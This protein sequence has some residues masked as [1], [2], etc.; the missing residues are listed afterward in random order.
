MNELDNNQKL[1]HNKYYKDIL[2]R[3]IEGY[4]GFINPDSI[5]YW[6]HIYCLDSIK[7][8]FEKIPKSYFLTVGDGY[9]GREAGFIKRFG[10]KVH[11]SD[12]ETCLIEISKEK[13]IIDEYSEQDINM[14]SFNDNFFDYSLV[15]ESL[16]HLSKPYNGIYEMMRVSKEGVILIEPNGDNYKK[17][18]FS[19]FEESGN[20]CFDFN[21]HELY[22]IGLSMG[23][24]Y[25]LI[26]YSNMFYGQHN[27]DN[28][29]ND[30]IVEEKKRLI[31]I[32]H[33]IDL[34]YKPLLIF[35][36]LKN[37]NIYDI[38]NGNNFIKINI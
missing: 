11:A 17:Y 7:E 26:S 12:I 27:L 36:F 15:K 32:D 23:Y 14:L 22:K 35:I 5:W 2:K 24:K 16:H 33:K 30:K 20:Y 8:F 21:S 25:F 3:G 18:K 9:C 28:I 37:K 19:H 10:H 6:M 1:Y 34:I 31:E 38:I 29:K 4:D 13:N